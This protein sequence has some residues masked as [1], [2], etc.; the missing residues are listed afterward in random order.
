M[1][2]I[3]LGCAFLLSFTSQSQDVVP[4]IDFNGFFKSFQ[5]GFF[6][7]IEFQPIKS[8]KA[9]DDVV[10]YIDFRGNLRVFDGS[11]PMDLANMNVEYEVSDNLLIWKIGETINM[12]DDG[13]KQTL[14]FNGRNYW[15][16]DSIIVFE[17]LRYNS[18]NAYYKGEIHMLYTSMGDVDVPD[19]IGE[20]IVAFRDNGNFNKVFWRGNIYDLDVSHSPMTFHAGTDILAFNDPMTGT[21]AVFE[22]GQFLDVEDFH[23][24]KY[25]AGRGFIVYEN[26]NGDLMYYSNGKKKQ[27]S[28]FGADF[29]EVKDDIA[30]WGENSFTYALVNGEKI[31][32]ARYTPKDYVIKNGVVAFRNI[33]GGV[34]ALIDG[35]VQE[36]T[37]Q[38]NSEYSIFGNAVLIELFNN[39]Y[40]LFKDGRKF[41]L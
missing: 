34:S 28:N 41:S 3:L 26:Q 9:G 39:S 35:K 4:L 33:M 40:I 21:F 30:V 12:W 8:F 13:R 7:Q 17:D 18:V 38:M 20:N 29:W 22:N 14:T 16:R 11:K 5:N 24:G 32:M 15:V 36:I 31:E 10:A 25:K 19:F 23:M 37:T 6:R 2:N 27:L 1:K